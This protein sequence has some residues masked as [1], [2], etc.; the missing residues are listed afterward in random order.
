M[1]SL[2]ILPHIYSVGVVD[3]NMREF[4]GHTYTTKRG[5]SY[6]SYLII[7][8][9]I[10][11]VDAVAA[12]FSQE[13]L[14]NIA[15]VVDPAKIDYVIANHVESDHSGAYPAVMKACP[16]AKMIGTAKCK[17]GLYKHYYENWD[18][19]V[20]KTGDK[21]KLGK[22]TLTFIEAPMIHWPDSMFTYCPEEGLLMSNDA[23]GQHYATSERFDDE[24]DACALMDEASKYY[25][26]ILW[27]LGSI[28]LRKIEEIQK[29][30]VPL[31]MIAPS[32]GIIWRTEPHKIVNE[33]VSWA[34]GET[35]QKAV[36]AYESMWGSTAAMARK[37][38]EGLIEG[39][40]MTRIFDVAVSD[41][42]EVVN[43]MLDAR[44]F[45]F[46]SST[47]DNDM[48]PSM[49][50]FMELVKG[51]KPRA[52]LAGVFGSCGWAGGAIKEIEAVVQEAGIQL[53]QE[54]LSVKYVPD[55]GEL[56]RCYEFGKSLAQKIKG[57]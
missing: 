22:R 30:N 56:K 8:D 1:S 34:K 53:A 26:N 17:E 40:I 13:L 23:F 27:P 36:V 5:T 45:C 14:N 28:I 21:V 2:K 29:M 52:R 38:A 9:K 39:G 41:R 10:A 16:N 42:T 32:H 7:D 4:H 46:G 25:A 51:F 54:S 3:W 24:T 44:A 48:L 50:A 35:K 15:Q 6:N 33:Y 31:T 19:Q 12:P 11:L 43:A 18:F 47:H 37:I 20:V 55:E 49:A 57:G